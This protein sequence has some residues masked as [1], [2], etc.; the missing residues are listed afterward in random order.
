MAL[1][2]NGRR[3]YIVLG[4]GGYIGSHLLDALLPD[5]SVHVG[6]STPTSARSIGTSA[7]PILSCTNGTCSRTAAW[8]RSPRRSTAPTP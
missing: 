6:A 4:C 7:G 3:K 5:S 8:R 1:S 2:G